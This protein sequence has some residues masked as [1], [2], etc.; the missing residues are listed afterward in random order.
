LRITEVKF[1]INGNY[2]HPFLTSMTSQKRDWQNLVISADIQPTPGR[3]KVNNRPPGQYLPTSTT[4]AKLLLLHLN[5]LRGVIKQFADGE[6]LYDHLFFIHSRN[7]RE[8]ST[9][10]FT[11]SLQRSCNYF[12]FN[13]NRTEI[14]V[15]PNALRHA[16]VTYFYSA[17]KN[18]NFLQDVKTL[19][20]FLDKISAKLNT[21]PKQ[22]LTTYIE[23]EQVSCS[24][25]ERLI[26]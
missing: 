14:T 13:S 15:T 7:G 9:S 8:I 18:K 4:T 26:D 12:L 5:V 23:Q 19:E 21:S 17:W 20:E 3:E 1:N 2:H 25:E 16:F 10:S 24:Q 22:L 6:S 11:N